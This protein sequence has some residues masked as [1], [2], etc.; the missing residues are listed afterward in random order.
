MLY[1]PNSG[2]LVAVAAA[3]TTLWFYLNQSANYSRVHP[4]PPLLPRGKLWFSTSIHL[5]HFNCGTFRLILTNI[6]GWVGCKTVRKKVAAIKF[7]ADKWREESRCWTTST[8][9]LCGRNIALHRSLVLHCNISYRTVLIAQ[10]SCWKQ[11]PPLTSTC[12]CLA[13]QLI[14]LPPR[15]KVW[16]TTLPV[17][18]SNH[19]IDVFVSSLYCVAA[20][21]ADDQNCAHSKLALL[22]EAG[23]AKST[24]WSCKTK[25]LWNRSRMSVRLY[26]HMSVTFD[27]LLE[28]KGENNIMSWG[29]CMKA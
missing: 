1:L 19:H 9:S 25:R 4:R 10:S 28:S 26:G 7:L 20:F 17:L 2:S 14:F 15:F 22:K 12:P 27:S 29:C 24:W 11:K 13:S 5:S 23:P 21:V 6:F 8:S 3:S 18:H 16:R